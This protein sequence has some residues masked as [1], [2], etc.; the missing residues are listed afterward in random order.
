MTQGGDVFVLDMGEP[1]KILD[2]AHRMAQ[3]S[4]MTLRDADHPDGD[5]EIEVSG[6]RP[7]EKLYEELLIGNNPEGTANERIMKAHE[8]FVDWPELAPLLVELRQSA[9]R[10]DEAAIKKTLK[11][12]VDGYTPAENELIVQRSVA[13]EA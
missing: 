13:E 1:V 3:L 10:N 4:G 8:A 11:Q 6:L 9:V 12:L 5:I 7:G 2:L